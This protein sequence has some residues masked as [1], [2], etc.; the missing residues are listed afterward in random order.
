MQLRFFKYH[1][2]GNDFILIDNRKGIIK[3]LEKNA[4]E[5]L[6]HRRF[7][8]GADGLILF[9]KSKG[10]DFEMEYYN[11]DGRESTMCGN[12]GRCMVQFAKDLGVIKS[13]A[14]F[15]AIDGEHEGVISKQGIVSIKMRDV[16]AFEHSDADYIVN[17]GSPH[18]VK[19]VR[20]VK[21]V[22]VF[23]EGKKI[24]NQ[25]KFKKEGIN[26]NFAE[27]GSDLLKVRTYERGV[28]DET[29]SCGTGVVAS[30]I[31]SSVRAKSKE[32]NR[33]VA[34][35]TPGGLF[36]VSF[37]KE[38]NGFSNIW[39]TGGAAFVFEGAVDLKKFRGK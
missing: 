23:T 8:I 35:W 30:A 17:T 14:H 13:K 3:E 6:C 28:E 2:N 34:L 33:Q 4:I 38:Q 7:G 5:R 21:S 37:N 18:Y 36:E 15:L 32:G 19:F 25:R 39:L 27:P 22:D 16:E 29:Y 12:G 24:R 26:V 11:S 1:G 31:I 10:Y 20:N 9:N